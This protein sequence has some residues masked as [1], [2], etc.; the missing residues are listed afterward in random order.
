[1]EWAID[2]E[3]W[4]KVLVRMG[5]LPRG[6][7]GATELRLLVHAGYLLIDSDEVLARAVGSRAV[8]L[9]ARRIKK[10]YRDPKEAL[11]VQA[12]LVGKG[13]AVRI[14]G[15][16]GG[17]GGFIGFVLRHKRQKRTSSE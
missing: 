17:R 16:K 11:L 1:M 12:S 13:V 9:A 5:M 6:S 10:R 2:R 15:E 3:F 7:S 14:R 4:D 8:E